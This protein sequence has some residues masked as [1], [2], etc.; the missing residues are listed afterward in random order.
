MISQQVKVLYLFTSTE[1]LGAKCT[2]RIKNKKTHYKEYL[3]S[4]VHYYSTLLLLKHYHIKSSL[5]LYLN[6]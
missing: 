2:G 4:V 3:C 6:E 5:K 1:V